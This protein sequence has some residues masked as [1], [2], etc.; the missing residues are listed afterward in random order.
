MRLLRMNIAGFRGFAEP[1]EF[2][3]DADVVMVSGPNGSGKTS[4]LDAILWG[5]TGSVERIGSNDDLVNR[6]GDF[7]DARVEIVLRSRAGSELV[8]VRRFSGVETLTVTSDGVK[9][10]GAAARSSL[11]SLL[12]RDGGVSDDSL[13]SLSRSLTRSV[14]LQQD[15][16]NAFIQTDDAKKRFEIVGE[17]IG[18]G[19]LNE[20]N[21]QLDSS[22]RAWTKKT[23]AQKREADDLSRQRDDL[24]LRLDGIDSS[25]E[26]ERLSEECLA[27]LR[28]V[29]EET[30]RLE[31]EAPGA[32]SDVAGWASAVDTAV[33]RIIGEERVLEADASRCAEFRDALQELSSV[34]T[35]DP[36]DSA[37]AVGDLE[38]RVAEASR[39]LEKAEEA[40]SVA[41]RRRLARAEESK[42]LGG[43]AQFAL[44]H[45]GDICPVCEQEYDRQRTEQRLHSLIE[46]SGLSPRCARECGTPA[47]SRLPAT[48]RSPARI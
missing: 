31:V 44:K 36:K 47:S 48:T 23:N 29:N 39:E 46:D 16:V 8:V 33:R 5:L 6:F 24:K 19:R 38:R 22:R 41:H 9:K 37:A 43:M 10:S 28:T 25:V 27:W 2:D 32:M 14:Y 42:S 13:E 11:S 3:L 18:V 34:V 4:F 35:A 21:R 1:V 26:P 17:L 20:L 12:C 45:L 40:A 7:G 15:R 30:G